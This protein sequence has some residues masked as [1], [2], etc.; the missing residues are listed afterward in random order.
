MLIYIGGET[1]LPTASSSSKLQRS[2]TRFSWAAMRKTGVISQRGWVSADLGIAALFFVFI[3]EIDFGFLSTNLASLSVVGSSC[4]FGGVE[5]AEPD[6]NAF[7]RVTYLS[8]PFPPWALPNP[9][10]EVLPLPLHRLLCFLHTTWVLTL[11][12]RLRGAESASLSR[13]ICDSKE[14]GLALGQRSEVVTR[15]HFG[16]EG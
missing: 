15:R 1:E 10:V 14:L 2:S 11:C 12:G 6:S 16:D 4:F 3:R 13:H 9:S 5:C 7:P 8:G